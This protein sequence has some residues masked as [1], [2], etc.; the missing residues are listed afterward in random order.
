MVPMPTQESRNDVAELVASYAVKH[1]Q[2][3]AGELKIGGFS[4]AGRL[5]DDLRDRVLNFS[6]GQNR[7]Y[8]ALTIAA[9]ARNITQPP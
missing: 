3:M 9:T 1:K 8:H 4:G 6:T 5:L 7:P 2:E